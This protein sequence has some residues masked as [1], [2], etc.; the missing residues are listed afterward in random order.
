MGLHVLKFGGTSVGSLKRLENVADIVSAR[1][2]E[3]QVIVVLSAMSGE[4]D[5][6]IEQA[7]HFTQVPNPRELD[8]LLTVGEQKSVA[9]FSICMLARGIKAK[10][11]LGSQI[12]IKTSNDHTK[13][14]ITEI[15]DHGVR[16]SLKRG[17]I[18][19]VPG[20]QGVTETGEL[21]TLGRGGSDT[22]AVAIAAALK[23]DVCDIYTDVEGVYTTDPNIEPKA[24]K[25][26]SITYD[27][28][29]ELASLG[30]KV[31][32]TRSVEFA[33]KYKVPLHVRSTFKDVQG[34]WVLEE[35]KLME[36]L[37]VSGI[38]YTKNEAKV[39]VEGMPDRV[40]IAADLF[41]KVGEAGVGVDVIVQNVSKDQTTDISFTVPRSDLRKAIEVID[42]HKDVLKHK[43]IRG[44]DRISKISV[45]GNG[46]RSHSGVAARMFQALAKENINI[47]MIST[48]EIKISCVIDE[49]YSELA[50]RVLHDCF[51]LD[52]IGNQEIEIKEVNDF[53]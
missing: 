6:L 44:D 7:K 49:K 32:Q 12:Q 13:A 37:V 41:M 25:L 17:E 43:Q 4:T 38:T 48:S 45:I 26:S 18:V 15:A 30:A 22:T 2:K 31:L 46:M 16:A 9:L 8:V 29:L 3:H 35:S 24:K 5:S 21:T 40:G 50:V 36:A 11:F 51:G 33:K 19:V 20:F 1:A 27:E 47:Q 28:M 23:A 52:K 42:K 39:V 53:R 34:T 10:S 14:R